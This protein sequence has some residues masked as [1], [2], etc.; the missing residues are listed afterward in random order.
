MAKSIVLEI[1]GRPN[2]QWLSGSVD[3]D[4]KDFAG[5]FSFTFRDAARSG[6]ALVL[7]TTG[8]MARLKPGPAVTIRIG[9]R[10]VLK[11]SIE[12]VEPDL[13]DLQA[14]VTISGRDVTGDLIDGA[15]M[16]DAGEFKDVKL[17]DAAARIAQPY[18]IS[19]RSEIDTGEVF[20]RYSIDLAETAFSAI[21]KGARSRHALILSDGIG[22]IV[23]TRTGKTWAP[24]ALVQPGNVL[25]ARGLISHEE[26]FSETIVRGQAEGA[27]TRRGP[28]RLDSTAEPLAA[29]SR[30]DGDGSASEKERKGIIAT[31]R[32]SDDEIRRY[33]P[34]V[35]LARSKA[36]QTS[37]QDEADFR[38]RSA[39]ATSEEFSLTVK[40][41]EVA[42]V[43]W[44]VNQL[45]DVSV[46]FLDVDRELLISRVSYVED[47]SGIATEIT[48][49]SPEAFDKE[50]VAGRRTNR[51]ARTSQKAQPSAPLDGTASAL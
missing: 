11:G 49:C 18:G 30:P 45:V 9:R 34:I 21:E 46:A 43:L 44:T 23:I 6:E 32:A 42:G 39:R 10:I 3:R 48:V 4:L 36:D 25:R 41:H 31:G 20:P 24:A 27:A 12:K 2:D 5:S 28:A 8:P 33:R 51:K 17:E 47:Y 19:V 15:A 50:P 7:A 37:A 14:S 26:R 22:G 40:G 38:M 13:G 1:D 35:H 16:T 29:D